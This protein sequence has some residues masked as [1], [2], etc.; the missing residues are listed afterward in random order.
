MRF[1]RALHTLCTPTTSIAFLC[2]PTAFV[3]FQHTR[4]LPHARLLELDGRFGVLA[5]RQY[6]PYDMEEPTVFPAYLSGSVDVAVVD[7]PFLNEVSFSAKCVLCLRMLTNS[8]SYSPRTL[9]S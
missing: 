1:A 6:V 5:P 9:T 7:P 4:P 2:C 3:A 8:K